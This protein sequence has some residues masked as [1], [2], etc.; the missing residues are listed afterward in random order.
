MSWDNK[1]VWSEGMFLR[2]QH[3]Q[4]HDRYVEHLVRGRTAGIA[5][6]RWGISELA[7]NRQLLETGGFAVSVC[8]GVLPDGTPFSIPE[9][10]DHPVPLEPSE[11]VRDR[12]VYLCLP[13]RQPGGYDFAGKS[14]VDAIT[15][16]RSSAFQATDAVVGSEAVAELE[17]GKLDLT[18]AL[19]GAETAGYVRIGLARIQEVG[20]DRKIKLDESYIPPCL[21]CATS[22]MLA[23]YITELQ[24]LLH[25]RGAALAGRVAEA[26]GKATGEIADFLFLLLVNRSLPLVSHLA[27]CADLHPETLY[28]ALVAMAGEMATFTEASKRPPEFPAYDH[29]NLQATFQPV[30]T[31][32]RRSLSAV[33]EQT[34]IPIPLQERKYGIRVGQI[35]DRSLLTSASFVLAVRADAPSQDIRR[36]FPAQVKIGP[37]E[38]IRNLVNAALPGIT[39]RPL[40]VAPRQIPFSAGVTYFELD[41]TGQFWKQLGQSGGLA[42]HL[43]GDFPKAELELWA[44]R[45]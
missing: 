6:Y 26:G 22:S 2:P 30:V 39:V 1:V 12:I 31:A 42:I 21:D 32:L 45:G 25:Q 33:L 43:A 7:V 40:P 14:N 38:Q 9:D 4:Q 20:A 11:N 5:P 17:I 41:R 18:Y 44:I 35:A 36:H 19:H 27:A 23:G 10:T 34:A 16:Y 13:V 24:G 37:V 8:R 15:R 3:F 28:Q 29:E